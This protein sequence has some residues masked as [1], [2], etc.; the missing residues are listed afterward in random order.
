MNG[1]RAGQYK[2]AVETAAPLLNH[3]ASADAK[4]VAGIA[5]RHV[6]MVYRAAAQ[7]SINQAS[8]QRRSQKRHKLS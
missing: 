1:W 7:S 5:P 4:D 2:E 3:L 6:A 8:G